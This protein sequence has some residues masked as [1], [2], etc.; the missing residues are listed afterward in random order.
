[1]DLKS[2][3]NANQPLT[4]RSRSEENRSSSLRDSDELEE[5]R[6]KKRPSDDVSELARESVAL[7]RSHSSTSSNMEQHPQ[8]PYYASHSANNQQ[9]NSLPSFS[10]LQT[11]LQTPPPMQHGSPPSEVNTPGMEMPDDSL[12]A[13]VCGEPSCRKGFAR[14]SDL[15]RHGKYLRTTVHASSNRL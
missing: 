2:I 8:L 3:L 4:D 6:S 11:A 10:T 1:M 9:H 12:R 7:L 14:R 13:F 15:V 5:I